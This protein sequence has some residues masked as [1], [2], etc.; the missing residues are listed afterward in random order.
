MSTV[1]S[2]LCTSLLW[3]AG[4]LTH[5]RKLLDRG[6]QVNGHLRL[7]GSN[8]TILYWAF[9]QEHTEMIK[10]LLEQGAS[11]SGRTKDFNRRTLAQMAF[12]LDLESMAHILQRHGWTFHADS[13]VLGRRKA[14]GGINGQKQGHY[15]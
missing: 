10:L 5:I 7:A 12:Y 11:W 3:P 2:S 9:A 13:R 1:T 8:L 6:A 15:V 14:M 4:S